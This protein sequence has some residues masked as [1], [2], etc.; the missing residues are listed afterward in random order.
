MH[1]EAFEKQARLASVATCFRL[2]L[3]PVPILLKFVQ[4][5]SRGACS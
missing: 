1:R 4:F 3:T 2:G 5:D